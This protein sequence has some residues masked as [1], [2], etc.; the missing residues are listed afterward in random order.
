VRDVP[1]PPCPPGSL[2]VRNAFSLISSGTERSRVVSAQKSLLQRARERPD[3]VRAVAQRAAKEGLASTRK[4]VKQKLSEG[5]AVGYSSAGAVVEVGAAAAGFAPGDRVACAGV[6]HANH[7]E[8]VSVPTNLCVK[9]PEGVPLESASLSAVAAIAL[10]S[11]RLGDVRIGDR[12]AVIGCGLVGQI[13]CRLLRAAGAEV[14]ALD[15]DQSRLE[16][17]RRSGADH[18]FLSDAEAEHRVFAATGQSG[19]DVSIIAAATSSSQ[20]LLV[21]ANIA[22]ERGNLILVGDVPIDIPREPL[23]RKELRFRISRSYGPGRYDSDYEERG[24]DYPIGYVRWTEKRNM[25]CIL[26]LQARGVLEL[27]DLVEEVF[28]VE[29]A[30]SAYER[31]AGGSEAPPRGALLISYPQDV[32]AASTASGR[33]SPAE[34]EKTAVT[35]DVIRVG[36]IGPGGF[37][38]ST[39]IPALVKAGAKLEVVGGGAGP[40]ADAL[41]REFGFARVAPSERAVIDDAV[42]AVVICTRHSSHA[43]LVREALEAGKHVFCEKPLA[44]S[45]D[46]LSRVLDSAAQSD[47]ILA[48]GFNR[49]FSPLLQELRGFVGDRESPLTLT[50]RVAAGRLPADHWTNDLEQGG[51]RILGEAC[52]FVDSLVYLVGTEIVEVHAIGSSDGKPIQAR[53]NVIAGLAFADGSVGT[54]LYA[55]DVGPGVPKELIEV[56]SDA[57]SGS[58]DDFRELH[59]YPSSGSKH[60]GRVQH[61][62]HQEEIAAFLEGI[63]TGEAPVDLEEIVNVSVATLAIV[64]S[65]RTGE[66]VRLNASGEAPRAMNQP[67]LKE[68]K[69][70]T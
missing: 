50:Y 57:R 35:A 40:S 29:E 25:E 43:R 45:L 20:P 61:K 16:D 44:L 69:G 21:A 31:L 2:L 68:D 36:V 65:L 4:A 11:I 34:R 19:V 46:D 17:A 51:G 53:D 30:A 23:Y 39:I 47:A 15:V 6:G 58:I 14:F 8:L 5:T 27:G 26:D 70:A 59:L 10:H 37:A 66:T 7:A 12:V 56:H 54:I 32:A 3:L 24:F 22:R 63:R 60:R 9:V 13:V 67:V 18:L 42:D 38:R 33:T 55:A 48:V 49:R 62:G 28:P 64:E 41:S 52:H 1:A